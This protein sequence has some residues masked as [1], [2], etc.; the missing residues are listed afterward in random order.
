MDNEPDMPAIPSEKL[1]P[2]NLDAE[3]SL[4]GAILS[5]RETISRV[6]D[7][8]APADFYLRSHQLIYEAA[9]NLFEKRENVDIL[10]LAG[11]LADKGKLDEIGGTTYLT[12]LAN[13][14]PTSV[15]AQTYARIVQRKKTLRDL[16]DTAHH[17]LA[18]GHREDED[19]DSLLEEAEQQ[20]FSVTQKTVGKTFGLLAGELDVAMERIQTQDEGALRG[21]A[22]HHTKL[23]QTL[24][25]F[26]R[27]DLIILAARP[28]VGKTAF[29]IDIARRVAESNIPVGIFSL[30]MSLD[31]VVDRL[32]AAKARTS[33]WRLRTGKLSHEGEHNDFLRI[34]N[35]ITEL[36]EMP[37]Y[38]DDTPGLNVLQMRAM[39]RR[40]KSEHGLG[41]LVVDYLQLMSARRNYDSLVTQVTEISRGLKAL[42]KELG[43]PVIAIS[44][45]SRA[46]ESREGNR[47]RLSDL[48]DSGSIEQDADVVMFIHRDDKINFQRAQSEGKLNQ[49]QLVIAKHRNGPTGEIDFHINPENLE[50]SEVDTVHTDADF[51]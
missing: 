22:S 5:D 42:A 28:S 46:I 34:T 45:L 14:V 11:R 27:S 41:L 3:R 31:Q 24:G 17:I 10:S 12:T 43:I 21:I 9:F 18:L 15:H 20:L 33:L 40:L 49:A 44:Q 30:E 35:A 23:D 48:R 13:A 29:A 8:V 37:I 38:I 1:P 51:L 32:I 16:V 4:L 7:T 26:Q 19:V 50:F 36:R 2:Q 47:P 39:A 6:I 25:G